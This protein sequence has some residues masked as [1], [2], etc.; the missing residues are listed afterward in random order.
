[1]FQEPAD[2]IVQRVGHILTALDP[3]ATPVDARSHGLA[4]GQP[5][6]ASVLE[7]GLT[8]ISNNDLP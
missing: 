7:A 3:A 2:G 1:L 6:A 4:T 8:M 5:R